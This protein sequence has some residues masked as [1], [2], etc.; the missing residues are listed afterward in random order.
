[1]G[2]YLFHFLPF[3]RGIAFNKECIMA[4]KRFLKTAFI[5]LAAVVFFGLVFTSCGSGDDNSTNGGGLQ[6]GETSATYQSVKDGTTYKLTVTKKNDKAAYAPLIGDEYKLLIIKG[7]TTQTS[8]GTISSFI[9]N[10]FTLMPTNATITFTLKISGNTIVT[11]NGTI[12]L[13]GSGGTVQGPGDLQSGGNPPAGNA[14]DFD[15]IIIGGSVTITRYKGAGGNVAIPAAIEGK[16]V[17]SIGESAFLGCSSL[18]SVTIP[19]SVTSI[20]ENVFLLCTSLSSVTIGN[21]V[22]N[23]GYGT[24][25]KCTSL[26]TVTIP[27]KRKMTHFTQLQS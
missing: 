24:F 25:N 2:W 7:G 16:P 13:E 14:G 10:V 21:G 11:I 17:T 8:S 4:H 9:N 27:D 22:T 6:G 1:M 15:Y 20:G 3:F 23:I 26:R 5:V 12:T 19:D 18:E